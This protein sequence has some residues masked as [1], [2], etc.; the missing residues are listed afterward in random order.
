MRIWAGVLFQ[1]FF[2][3]TPA[4]ATS[5]TWQFIGGPSSVKLLEVD[6]GNSQII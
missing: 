4:M 6:P 2:L 3:I 1:L 5:T